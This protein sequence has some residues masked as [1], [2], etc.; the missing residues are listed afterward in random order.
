M[1][2]SCKASKQTEIAFEITES[3][4]ATFFH[5]HMPGVGTEPLIDHASKLRINLRSRDLLQM[6][7]SKRGLLRKGSPQHYGNWSPLMTQVYGHMVSGHRGTGHQPLPSY[8]Q[9][10][11]I[12]LHK[13]AEPASSYPPS[14]LS[15]SY[16]LSQSTVHAPR[17]RRGSA[18]SC[19][20]PSSQTHTT[21]DRYPVSTSIL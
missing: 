3:Q 16:S 2:W 4:N 14:L 10:V 11:V 12:P 21:L 1:M 15:C 18:L 9:N 5:H 8:I 13:S 7:P 20:P 17:S 6:H 19:V